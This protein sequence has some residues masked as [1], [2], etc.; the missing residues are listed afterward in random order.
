MSRDK[1]EK[2]P[3]GPGEVKTTV[4]ETAGRTETHHLRTEDN[5]AKGSKQDHSHVA[6]FEKS[7]GGKTGHGFHSFENPQK[8]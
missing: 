4:K 5:A 2:D 1:W 3:T 6:V 8:K 7:D